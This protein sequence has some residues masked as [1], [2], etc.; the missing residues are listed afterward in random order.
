M[1]MKSRWLVVLV[2]LLATLLVA[3]QEDKTGLKFTNETECGTA[4]ITITNLE[5]GNID[6][7]TVNEGRTVEIE[8]DH[9]TTYRYTVEYPPLG[10]D[11]QCDSKEVETILQNGQMLNISLESVLAPDL[12]ASLTPAGE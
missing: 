6:E 2:I 10:D 4:T 11:L 9:N 1:P 8:L 3:C 7:L 12:E 5:T